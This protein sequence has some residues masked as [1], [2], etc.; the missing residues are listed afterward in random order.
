L[1]VGDEVEITQGV[2]GGMCAHVVNIENT[3]ITLDTPINGVGEGRAKVAKWIK[4]GEFENT[5]QI[6]ESNIDFA[7]PW[8]RIKVYTV[9]AGKKNIYGFEL[10]NTKHQ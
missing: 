8:V 10:T 6:T 7:S 2:G 5:D 9:V 1:E 3:T 4:I